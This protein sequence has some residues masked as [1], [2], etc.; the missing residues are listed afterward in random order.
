MKKFSI[1]A[2]FSEYWNHNIRV[3]Y[4]HTQK[5]YNTLRYTERH[6]TMTGQK[7]TERQ[8]MMAVRDGSIHQAKKDNE[9]FHYEF[10]QVQRGL[11]R[12][13]MGKAPRE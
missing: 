1:F 9:N 7:S 12:W 5:I 6:R 13:K 11:S 4:I 3:S 8:A 10:G 2:F